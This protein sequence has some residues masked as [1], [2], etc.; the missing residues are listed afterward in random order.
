MKFN[1]LFTLALLMISSLMSQ[2]SI[3]AQKMQAMGLLHVAD[4][5]STIVVDMMYAHDDNFT[6]QLLYECLREAY[7][8]PDALKGVIKAQKELKRLFP[9]YTLII[10]DAARPM[11]IQK[12]MWQVVRGTPLRIYVANPANGGGLH[13]Y[14]LAVDVSILDEKGVSLPMGTP[15]DHLGEESH[16]THEADLISD[17]KL[18]KQEW[19]NRQ[20][21]RRV[22]R[23]GGYRTLHSE[24]WHFNWCSRQ[25]AR[26]KYRVIP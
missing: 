13:N 22:M 15:V 10:Y 19:E 4:S 6:G 1:F 2:Q 12:K 7:L 17:G 9:E 14:G 23:H 21:L 18:T 11:H 5:D 25:E 16:I 3:E 8:H 24:W 26:E 20:L